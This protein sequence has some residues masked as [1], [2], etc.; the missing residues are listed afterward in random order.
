M[1]KKHSPLGLIATTRADVTPPL[2]DAV[3]CCGWPLLLAASPRRLAQ[4]FSVHNPECVL[5]WL[6]ER[7]NM[8]TLARLIDWSRERGARPYRMAVAYQMDA[9][10]EAVFRAAGVHAFL[11]IDGGTSTAVADALRP[12]LAESARTAA[13]AAAAEGR[14]YAAPCDPVAALARLSD[15]VRPP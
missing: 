14:S 9:D 2:D 5:F 6:E 7:Q 13:A 1:V 11:P 8:P 3:R 12:L 10:V 4:E 15:L